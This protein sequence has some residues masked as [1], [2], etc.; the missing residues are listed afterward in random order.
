MWLGYYLVTDPEYASK[1]LNYS[2]IEFTSSNPEVG[3]VVMN[4][5]NPVFEAYKDGSATVTAK[6]KGFTTSMNI[7]VYTPT[8]ATSMDMPSEVTLHKG[9]GNSY[10]P[11]FNKHADK[12]ITA[13]LVSGA[14]IVKFSSY[15]TGFYVGA[16]KIGTAVV[17]VTST[18]NPK[19]TKTVKIKTVEGLPNGSEVSIIDEKTKQEYSSPVDC[20]NLKLN[21][22]YT[23][24]SKNDTTEYL[25]GSNL[26]DQLL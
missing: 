9:Y 8:P 18:S 13:E 21:Q 12:S 10:A 25:M 26:Y 5:S 14:D 3:K 20:Y 2:E 1:T 17:K 7:D 23:I 22:R 19:L 11:K 15:S 24:H 6:Y 4:S 16:N